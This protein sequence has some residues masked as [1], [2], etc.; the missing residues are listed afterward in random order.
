MGFVYNKEEIENGK[1]LM[2]NEKNKEDYEGTK[3]TFLEE[4]W[5]KEVLSDYFIKKIVFEFYNNESYEFKNEISFILDNFKV[6]TKEKKR[7]GFTVYIYTNT[8]IYYTNGLPND[9]NRYFK[10]LHLL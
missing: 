3:Y 9:T 10:Q 6:N 4:L 5:L 1:L 2:E 7:W 8:N